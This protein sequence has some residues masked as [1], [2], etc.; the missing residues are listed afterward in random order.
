MPF[1]GSAKMIQPTFSHHCP[2]PN[3]RSLNA[4]S[5][6][7][8]CLGP[9]CKLTQFETC[10]TVLFAAKKVSGDVSFTVS[11]FLYNFLQSW[12]LITNIVGYSLR[13]YGNYGP[14][15]KWMN[16]EDGI[17]VHELVHAT[18]TT[19]AALSGARVLTVRNTGIVG[20]NAAQG[21][22]VCLRLSV[23]CCLV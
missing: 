15:N 14:V 20:S 19:V 17:I 10:Y 23:L 1:Q 5:N 21:M 3:N 7:R 11:S 18:A 9:L 6:T 8:S 13:N 16:P 4:N 12:R 22:D 2:V